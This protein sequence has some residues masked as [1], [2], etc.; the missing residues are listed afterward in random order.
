MLTEKKNTLH[1]HPSLLPLRMALTAA[2]SESPALPF[3][4]DVNEQLALQLI[5]KMKAEY[6]RSHPLLNWRDIPS[7]HGYR[8]SVHEMVTAHA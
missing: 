5:A 7:Q 6:K 8:E 3:R 2:A 4:V 1:S